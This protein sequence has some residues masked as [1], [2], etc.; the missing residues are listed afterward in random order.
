M[1]KNI[2]LIAFLIAIVPVLAFVDCG[3]GDGPTTPTTTTL[4]P[5]TTPPTTTLPPFAQL[6]GSPSPPP[7][8]GMKVKVQTAVSGNRWQL[9][10]RPIVQNVDGYCQRVGLDGRQCDTRPEGHAQREACDALVV[11]RAKDTGRV[12]PT[13]YSESGS[14]LSPG[15]T[16][17]NLACINSPDNQFL[18]VAR[19]PGQYLACASR[20]AWPQ[21]SA[22]EPC[23]GCTL[24]AGASICDQ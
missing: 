13:W 19:G 14:C 10:S 4:P 7:L 21:A 18:V 16:G 23:G 20:D 9:D 24:K 1:K 8:V 6:C 17:S 12:G 11:G 5:V 22:D 2:A 3:S 15:D